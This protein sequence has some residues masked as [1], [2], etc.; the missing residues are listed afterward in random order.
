MIKNKL[1]QKLPFPTNSL[2]FLIITVLILGIFFR[3]TNLERK[4]YWFDETY[5]SLRISGYTETEIVQKFSQPQII[6]IQD[7]QHYQ[8][9]NPNSTLTDTIKSLIQEDPQHPPLYYVT[10]R[11]WAQIFG[12][13]VTAMRSLPAL[14]SLLAFPS[15][16]W[17]CQEL[18]LSPLKKKSASPSTTFVTPSTPPSATNIGWLAAAILAVSPFHNLYAQEARQY[19]LWT[20][21]IL[22]SSAALLR[23]IRLKTKGS[24]IIYF[25]T[26]T[27]SFYTFLF[28]A[29]VAIGHGIY[30]IT[31]EKFRLTKTIISYCLASLAAIILFMPWLAV[32]MTSLSQINKVTNW[33]NQRASFWRWLQTFMGVLA[34]IF[35]D[36]NTR[37]RDPLIYLIAIAIAILALIALVSYSFYELM[38]HT[39]QRV[40][41]F[42]ATLV[43]VFAI[44]LILPD[45]IFGGNRSSLRFL[46]PLILGIQ[47]AVAYLLATK[48]SQNRN[49]RENKTW[50]IVTIILLSC[51][52]LS[53]AANS[54]AEVWWN[55]HLNFS[56]PA[57]ADIVNQ[58]PNPILISDAQMPYFLTLSYIL[59]PKVKL[60]IQPR[61]YTCNL[62]SKISFQPYIPQIPDGFTD[63]FLFKPKPS[64]E[65]LDEL[66][67][68]QLYKPE[69]VYSN[70]DDWLWKLEKQ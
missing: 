9:L 64:P 18:F 48:I 54:Q 22:L 5:T 30:I 51:G 66:K 1:T 16:Y 43:G 32:V 12:T 34:R 50:Q 7:L 60:M 10:A 19:S 58:A 26:L 25:I 59:D 23:A 53:C 17:L 41:L 46:T 67:K 3:L 39:P 70:P 69:L 2:R 36:F 52:I 21:T 68:Q 65:W 29:L 37:P 62:N 45:L 14:L 13:S 4:I 56:N 28:S 15:I 31:I 47:L 44:A 42:I 33:A 11:F 49:W 40:W 27:S 20:V 57:V 55:K 8:H 24:W 61:C 63:I 35:I 38:R 6:G